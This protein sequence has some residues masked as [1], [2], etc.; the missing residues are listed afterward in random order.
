MPG[1]F[2]PDTHA[3]ASLLQLAIELLRFRA[4]RQ[5]PLSALSG[6]R[7]ALPCNALGKSS[8]AECERK[9]VEVD[10]NSKIVC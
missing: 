10:E 8:A 4:M 7:I 5:A 6:F 2:D 1:R 9:L 3:Y